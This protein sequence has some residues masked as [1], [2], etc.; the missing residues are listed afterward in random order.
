MTGLKRMLLAALMAGSAILPAMAQTPE[1]KRGG[2][3]T[4]AL[5]ADIRSLEPGINRD[6]NTDALVHHIYEGLVGYRTDL[7]VGP[8]LAESWTV[9]EDGLSYS[10]T[11]RPGVRFH[12]GEPL[13]SAEVKSSWDRQWR[14]PTWGCRR[15]F[16]SAEGLQVTA[17]ETPDPQSIVYR[18][19]RPSA[20]FLTQLANIQCGTVVSHPASFGSDGKWREAIGTGPF[21]LREWRR[22]EFVALQR[23]EGYKP[24]PEPASAFAGARQAWLDEVLFR[25]IPDANAAEAGLLSGAVDLIP[26]VEPDRVATL[27]AQGMVVR[28]APGLGWT[29]MLLQTRDPL[30]QDVRIRRAIAHAIDMAQIADIRTGGG[31]PANASG[32]GSASS[33]FEPAFLAWPAYDP[34]RAQALL[35]EAGYRGQTIRLQTNRRYPGMYDNA[36]TVQA[37]LAAVGMKVELEVLDWATQL[38]N[39]LSGNFQMQSFSFSARL[40]PGLMYNSII[41]SKASAPWAQ[42]DDAEAIATLAQS[43]VTADPAQRRALFRKLHDGM[44][45]QV[46]IIGLYYDPLLAA[47]RPNVQG[48]APQSAGRMITWGA[49]LQ[50]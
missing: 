34:A 14:N 6:A 38:N 36:V 27:R 47:T 35:K 32:V 40:D 29:T 50:Q 24:S 45:Q 42:W 23:F 19:A 2:R 30:L 31:A 4:V 12:N 3:L 5:N 46:P 26:S 44:Q 15:Y 11:L 13:T 39:Y 49:W 9:S 22:G 16:D 7:S 20:L 37:M 48:Y 1:P 10:F 33:Y 43:A 25:V 17:V 18:L 8:A 21:R 41:G 28:T